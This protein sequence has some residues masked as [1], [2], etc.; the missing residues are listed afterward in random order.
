M[1]DAAQASPQSFEVVHG[2]A[3]ALGDYCQAQLLDANCGAACASGRVRH[4]P[5]TSLAP[6]LIALVRDALPKLDAL[7]NTPNISWAQMGQWVAAK[8]RLLGLDGRAAEEKALVDDYAH[9]HPEALPVVELR[10]EIL[11]ESQDA[12]EFEAQCGQS[13]QT[14]KG[15]PEDVRLE[16][17]A[18]CVALHPEN[19]SGREDPPD[20]AAYLRKPT[21]D[22][23]RLY[24]RYLVRRCE[25]D[26]GAHEAHCSR[27]CACD[28]RPWDK[29]YT[30]DCKKD[31]RGCRDQAATKAKACRR[32]RNR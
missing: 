22:E 9:Q 14:L 3:R 30:A 25:Q 6:E 4:K 18:A 15:A 31:C 27:T 28:D 1:Y 26:A 2:Y 23:Q 16:L 17:L 11:R 5:A 21:S 10:L 24:R 7:M 13:R 8:G 12:K 29:Q 20:V 19:P 32:L